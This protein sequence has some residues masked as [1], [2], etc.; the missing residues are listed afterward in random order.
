LATVTV[1]D[2]KGV[3]Q[4]YLD[5]AGFTTVVAGPLEETRAARHPRWPAALDNL[6]A[7]LSNEE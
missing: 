2:V 4:V 1:A 5:P 3:A 6:E 7:E